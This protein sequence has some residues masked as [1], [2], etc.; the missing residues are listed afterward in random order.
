MKKA[1]CVI[2]CM[3]FAFGFFSVDADALGTSAKA[4]VLMDADTGV[5]LSE[6]N[7]DLKLKMAS[8]TKIMT[9]LLALEAAEKEDAVVTFT[10]DMVAEGS[11]M[12]L[13]IGDKVRLSDLASGMMMASGND[14]ANAVALTLS[15]SFEGFADLMNTRAESI[16]MKNT[17]FVTPSGLDDEEHYST[18]FDMALL[19]AEAMKNKSFCEISASSS[20]TV[21]FVYPD[22]KV[23]V[24]H[25]HNRLLGMYKPCTGGKTG[26][27]KAAGRCLVTSSEKDG[28]RLIAVTLDAPD[29]WADHKALYEYGFSLYTKTELLSADRGFSVKLSG[30]EAEFFTA[31]PDENLTVFVPADRI[32][33]IKSQVYLPNFVFAP[34]K[35]G[36]VVGKISYTLDGKELASAYIKASETVNEKPQPNFLKRLISAIFNR[37]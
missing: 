23:T 26:Y 27:T 16:G 13:K 20:R 5:I 3:V 15:R 19:M 28:V 6:N 22:D 7:K 9:A 10:K 35:E 21:E 4:H 32:P 18:A 8:T 1:V 36:D 17:N 12:Y 33:D 37:D 31:S 29:D 34:V 25:N 2:F 24:Y 30:G 14:A 11:S